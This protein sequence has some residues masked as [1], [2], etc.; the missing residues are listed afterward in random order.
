MRACG[1]SDMLGCHRESGLNVTSPDVGIFAAESALSEMFRG[2]VEWR[3][4]AKN[5]RG[6]RSDCRAER[7]RKAEKTAFLFRL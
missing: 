4:K 6:M 2:D 3:E 7:K 5:A 1:N